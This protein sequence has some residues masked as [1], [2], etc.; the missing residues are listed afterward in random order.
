M[1]DCVHLY[2]GKDGGESVQCDDSS[3]YLSWWPTW[4]TVYSCTVGRMGM[5]EYSVMTLPYI[6]HG[7]K[8]GRLPTRPRYSLRAGDAGEVQIGRLSKTNH[9]HIFT[10]F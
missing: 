5:S 2:S 9:T 3:L 10:R 8:P 6:C 1:A 7:G 4:Q